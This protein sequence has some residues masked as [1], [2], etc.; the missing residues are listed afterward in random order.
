MKKS[1]FFH[2][3]TGAVLCA[4]LFAVSP[5]TGNSPASFSGIVAEAK[6]TD[7]SAISLNA[8]T[9]KIIIDD[10]Y[11]LRVYNTKEDQTIICKSGDS[12]VVTVKASDKSSSAFI[13][14]GKKC[15][16]AEITIRV[17]KGLT[18]VDTLKCNVTVG[19][20]AISV[21]FTRAKLKLS[22]N[23]GRTSLKTIL[24]PSDTV[25][26]PTY[27]SSDTDIAYVSKKG[28]VI[29]KAVGECTITAFINKKDDNGE[30]ICDSCKIIVTEEELPP[31]PMEGSE[32]TGETA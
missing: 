4:F 18:T 21:S 10:S 29:A 1:V 9:A 26:E 16:K 27:V 24:K 22:A 13:L 31:E 15:G 8:N 32:E 3:K 6:E 12:D 17:K 5:V 11:T 19:L 28:T 25:E 30:Y 2:V 7:S 20:P 14:K 23:G